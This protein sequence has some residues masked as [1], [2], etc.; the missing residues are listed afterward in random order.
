MAGTK[1]D[2]TKITTPDIVEGE[3]DTKIFP[4]PIVI[5]LQC[6]AMTMLQSKTPKKLPN[7]NTQKIAEPKATESV[8]PLVA[9]MTGNMVRNLQ[10]LYMI[11]CFWSSLISTNHFNS[12]QVSYCFR[13]VTQ[14]FFQL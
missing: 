2:S 7:E 5:G 6:K 11:Y 4:I 8:A 9:K 14:T 10:F 3:R 12:N 13:K 1:G